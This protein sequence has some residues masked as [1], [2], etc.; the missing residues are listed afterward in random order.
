MTDSQQ[1][2]QEPELMGGPEPDEERTDV[3]GGAD[4][5]GDVMSAPEPGEEHHDATGGQHGGPG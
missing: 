1:G 2:G 4:P 3:M 5:G